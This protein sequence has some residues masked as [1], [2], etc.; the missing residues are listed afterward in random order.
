MTMS[1]YSNWLVVILAVWQAIA[2][3]KVIHRYADWQEIKREKQVA[4][5][6]FESMM[7]K[8]SLESQ[9]TPRRTPS[10]V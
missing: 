10:M 8:D 9:V 2:L 4:M 3:D 1:S 5:E 7:K 6:E